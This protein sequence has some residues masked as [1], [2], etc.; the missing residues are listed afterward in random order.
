MGNMYFSGYMYHLKSIMLQ[1]SEHSTF[2][3]KV[4]CKVIP[5]KLCMFMYKIV[6]ILHGAYLHLCLSVEM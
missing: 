3:Q 1:K 2:E 4:I 6:H 5:I